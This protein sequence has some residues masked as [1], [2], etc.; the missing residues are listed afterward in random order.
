[1]A[2]TGRNEPCPCGSGKKYKKCCLDR[3][4]PFQ[5][6]MKRD[7]DIVPIDTVSDYGVPLP[8]KDFFEKNAIHE[9][10]GVRMLYSMM[11]NP[12]LETIVNRAVRQVINRGQEELER[13]KKAG[14]INTLIDIMKSKPYMMNQIPLIEKI[15]QD[16]DTAV[17]LI[18]Q[19]LRKPQNDSFVEL[20][21][22]ILH[23]TGVDC[24]GEIINIIKTGNNR[25]A[26]PIAVLSVLLGFYDS[27][28][29][30]KLLWDYYHH[31]KKHFPQE[32]YSDGPLLGLSE[33]R[34]RKKERALLN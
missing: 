29:T 20:S 28:A 34:E 21:A 2:H 23:R 26:Y 1:M 9:L 18:L 30:E 16:K 4:V 24:S 11:L 12:H 8:D 17:T 32:T 14:D 33:M 15:L 19:E 7:E 13:I 6:P 3:E 10:S 5:K 31:L 22:R 27:G 25:R